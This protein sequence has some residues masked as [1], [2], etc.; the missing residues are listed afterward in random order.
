MAKT[1]SKTCCLQKTIINE[2]TG[3]YV[4]MQGQNYQFRLEV[5]LSEVGNYHYRIFVYYAMYQMGVYMLWFSQH[6][7][8]V[9][10]RC[11]K[12]FIRYRS[13]TQDEYHSAYALYIIIMNYRN[14]KPEQWDTVLMHTITIAS[15]TLPIF[16]IMTD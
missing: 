12:L 3:H 10:H 1:A 7:N 4:H 11:W 9:F 15:V 8:I 13:A 5:V 2:P 16:R 6:V 14:G